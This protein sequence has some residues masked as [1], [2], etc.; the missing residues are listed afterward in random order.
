MV[1]GAATT[2]WTSTRS[3]RGRTS[4]CWRRRCTGATAATRPTSCRTCSSPCTSSSSS[5]ST[6]TAG[7]TTT[8]SSPATSS[9]TPVS[10]APHPSAHL[11]SQEQRRPVALPG[12]RV[13][14]ATTCLPSASG[15][16]VL[17]E[18][19]WRRRPFVPLAVYS[20][21]I[22]SFSYVNGAAVPKFKFPSIHYSLL[23]RYSNVCLPDFSSVAYSKNCRLVLLVKSFFV[24]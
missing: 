6:P 5:S 24:M 17:T 19:E 1:S 12:Y 23:K 9:S 22:Y 2:T 15:D 3:C 8:A 7:A 16:D 11:P 21:L 18:C 13:R 20:R 4:R 14:V 10:K